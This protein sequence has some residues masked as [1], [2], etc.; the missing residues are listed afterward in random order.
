MR[1]AVLSKK[2]LIEVSVPVYL[3]IGTKDVLADPTDVQ[4]V[5]IP[6]IPNIV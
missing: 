2:S 4:N 1:E 6:K 5:I 3:Y